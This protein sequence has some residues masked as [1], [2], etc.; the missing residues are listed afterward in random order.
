MTWIGEA[1]EDCVKSGKE[2]PLELAAAEAETGCFVAPPQAGANARGA[3]ASAT[4]AADP[5]TQ[6]GRDVRIACE[7]NPLSPDRKGLFRLTAPTRPPQ[8]R[9]D[10]R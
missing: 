7:A 6:R 5:T 4:T 9:N 3:N 8:P 2:P 1:P 10:P